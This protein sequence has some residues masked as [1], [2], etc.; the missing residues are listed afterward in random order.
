MKRTQ[1]EKQNPER[2]WSEPRK[3][4]TVKKVLNES[5]RKYESNS[6]SKEKGHE[7]LEGKQVVEARVSRSE[8]WE[9]KGMGNWG[10]LRKNWSLRNEEEEEEEEDWE[11]KQW[12]KGEND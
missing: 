9:M 12:K 2:K 8:D 3:N 1:Q 7:Y 10:F 6:E 4:W 11:Q 5:K